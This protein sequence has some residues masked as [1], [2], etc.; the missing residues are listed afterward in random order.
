M[1]SSATEDGGENQEH[2]WENT[3]E[4]VKWPQKG[5]IVIEVLIVVPN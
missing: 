5:G 3:L 2:A 4:T 1:G